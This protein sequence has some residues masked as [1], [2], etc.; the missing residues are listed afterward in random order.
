[1]NLQRDHATRRDVVANFRARHAVQPRL[2]RRPVGDNAQFVPFAVLADRAAL[3]GK[4]RSLL[5]FFAVRRQQ[6]AAPRLVVNAAAPHPAAGDVHVNFT[7]VAMDAIGGE[8]EFLAADQR[9]RR[10]G[11]NLAANLHA[12]IQ[13]R[14]AFVFQL[15]FKIFKRL[16]RAQETVPGA[17]NRFAGQ[18]AVFNRV[19]CLAAVLH[20]AGEI[21]AVEK[22]HPAVLREQPPRG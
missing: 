14:V 21:A 10:V 7:L 12:G 8:F 22:I 19:F 16:R 2:N 13:E 1:M 5:A 18:H 20:P 15:Q 11:K 6:P 4:C 3:S 17:G 9:V